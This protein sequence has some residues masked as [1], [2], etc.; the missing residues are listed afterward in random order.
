[1]FLAAACIALFGACG[2][3]TVDNGVCDKDSIVC[4]SSAMDS[5]MV[6]TLCVAVVNDSLTKE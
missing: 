5:T 4:D 3:N 2:N 1:M 6:D